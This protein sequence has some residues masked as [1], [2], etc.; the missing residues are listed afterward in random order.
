MNRLLAV[1]DR[2]FPANNLAPDATLALTVLL[3][4]LLTTEPLAP[5]MAALV[6]SALPP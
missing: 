2:S 4:V 3:M 5:A 6:E 1:I